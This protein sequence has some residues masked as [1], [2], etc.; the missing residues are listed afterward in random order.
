[1]Y[2]VVSYRSIFGL[3]PGPEHIGKRKF[4]S[5]SHIEVEDIS[6]SSK[7]VDHQ[8]NVFVVFLSL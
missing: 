6:F 4:H 8:H 1:M 3:K 2:R 5:I 7:F